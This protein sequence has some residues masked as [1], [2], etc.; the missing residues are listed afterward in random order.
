[1]KSWGYITVGLSCL[2]LS[3]LAYLLTTTNDDL[4]AA[5]AAAGGTVEQSTGETVLQLVSVG[6]FLAAVVLTA[7]GV[8]GAGVRAA[9]SD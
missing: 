9:R 4:D 5:I 6:L 1:M 3:F 2:V 7:I 8:I